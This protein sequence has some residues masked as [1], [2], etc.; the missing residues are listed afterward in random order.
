MLKL[1]LV[2]AWT[3]LTA[4][5]AQAGKQDAI[6]GCIDAVR[7]QVG[8]GGGEVLS[9]DP[10]GESWYVHLKDQAGGEWDCY[11]GDDGA[12][13]QLTAVTPVD[14]LGGPETKEARAACRRALRGEV[15]A[16]EIEVESADFSEA[17]TLVMMRA[18]DGGSWRCLSSSRG[19]V[20]ELMRAGGG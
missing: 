8:G 17:N 20:A 4:V 19:E 3:L 2:L 7:A 11:A 13:I 16:G 15:G 9:A 14:A 10:T 18:P 5:A 1:A 6:D 12:L